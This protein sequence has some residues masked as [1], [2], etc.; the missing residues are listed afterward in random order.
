MT[1]LLV[2][3]GMMG[4]TISS[5]P[6]ASKS[7]ATHS[8]TLPTLSKRPK[9]LLPSTV[10]ATSNVPLRAPPVPSAPPVMAKRHE[11][12]SV[13]PHGKVR[14]SLPRA[15]YSHSASVGRR[16][17]SCLQNPSACSYVTQL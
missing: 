11:C 9:G 4:S 2:R 14:P 5:L 6:Y 15:A 13:S 8:H 17:P 12:E 10:V 1:P 7:S 16:L 3:G